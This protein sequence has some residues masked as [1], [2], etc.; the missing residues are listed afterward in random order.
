MEAVREAWTDERLDDLANR[1]DRGFD[2][3]DADI[4][5]LRTDTKSEFG[6]A[7]TDTKSE[8]GKVR[9]ETK[10]EFGKVRAETKS[11]FAALREEM[12]ARFDYV[13]KRLERMDTRLDSIQRAIVFGS[14][15]LTTASISGFAAI[16][17]AAA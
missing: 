16:V 5:E 2:R 3:M 15:A 12:D 13:D 8:F 17:V 6:K 11:E 4:R 10:S 7:R 9:A 14:I 1:M